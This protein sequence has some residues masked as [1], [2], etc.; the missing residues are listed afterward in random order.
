MVAP[1]PIFAPEL[2]Q[3]N[4]VRTLCRGGVSDLVPGRVSDFVPGRG[5]DLVPGTC[6]R[7]LIKLHHS[8][9]VCEKGTE[10]EILRHVFEARYHQV[11]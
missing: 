1:G 11:L 5:L 9:I 8:A 7:T 4:L 2:A 3:Q 6:A 10:M